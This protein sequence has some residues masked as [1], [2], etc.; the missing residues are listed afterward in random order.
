MVYHECNCDLG[1]ACMQHRAGLK[2][3]FCQ[4]L[5]TEFSLELSVLYKHQGA[6]V[7]FDTPV[8]L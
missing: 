5:C 1:A 4:V 7:D 2:N 3:P 8:L 6:L